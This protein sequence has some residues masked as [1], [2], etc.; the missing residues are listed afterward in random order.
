W[1][2]RSS[3]WPPCGS[4]S[5]CPNVVR[6]LRE[7]IPKTAREASG[8]HYRPPVA[9]VEQQLPLPH[10]PALQFWLCGAPRGAVLLAGVRERERVPSGPL[11]RV[12]QCGRVLGQLREDRVRPDP[13]PPVLRVP[14]VRLPAVQDRVPEA[15]LRGR[16]VLADGVRLVEEVVVQPQPG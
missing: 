5:G 14:G 3:P 8:L 1:R 6:S 4:R 2:S 16:Q 7:R 13:P 11:P 10:L 9:P 15:P 12:P